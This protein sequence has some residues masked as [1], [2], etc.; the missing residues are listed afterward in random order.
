MNAIVFRIAYLFIFY[1]LFYG[2]NGVTAQHTDTL[3]SGS[4]ISY[5]AD[6]I[7][8]KGA[9]ESNISRHSVKKATL[10]SAI[11][12]GL[13]Q[14][15]NKKY[16]KIPIIYLGIGSIGY[17]IDFAQTRYKDFQQAYIW[18]A[19]ED[20]STIDNYDLNINNSYPKYSETQLKQLRDYYRRNRDLSI[21]IT[22]GI[23]ILNIM[24]AT[25]DA[26]FF[27]FDISK[28]L[29]IGI[30]PAIFNS[31]GQSMNSSGLSLTVKL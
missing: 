13:G 12:P 27:S 23:Y 21:I 11:L 29:T 31:Y 24:D 5:G 6:T 17:S 9:N 4:R 8:E 16:W 1:S 14:G 28:D 18:R 10:M 25:V 19:D 26:H 2:F 30:E 3:K 22:A 7:L 20:P 15:Y